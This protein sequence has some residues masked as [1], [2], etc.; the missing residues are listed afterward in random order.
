MG[1]LAKDVDNY[2]TQTKQNISLMNGFRD[3]FKD[4]KKN[5]KDIEDLNFKT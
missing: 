5:F 2:G 4:I 3:N 1:V